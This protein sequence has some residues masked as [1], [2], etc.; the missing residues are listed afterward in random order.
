MLRPE[1]WRS[2]AGRK[3]T[4]MWQDVIG[5]NTKFFSQKTSY[6]FRTISKKITCEIDLKFNFLRPFKF[7]TFWDISF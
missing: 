4:K 7:Y 2:G 6:K 3:H 1:V 5:L